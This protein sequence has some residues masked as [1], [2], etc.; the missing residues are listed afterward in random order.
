MTTEHSTNDQTQYFNARRHLHTLGNIKN[1][2]TAWE[3]SQDVGNL[4]KD[5]E[6]RQ[7]AKESWEF[8]I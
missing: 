5:S 3:F 1:A 6:I 2:S 7:H 8:L 4:R